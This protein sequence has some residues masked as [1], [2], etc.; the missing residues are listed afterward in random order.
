MLVKFVDTKCP[1]CGAYLNV[2]LDAGQANCQFCGAKLLIDDEVQ[3]FAYVNAEAAG[4]D[5]EKGRQRAQ[6]E[7][8]YTPP[9]PSPSFQEQPVKPKRKTWLWVLG[10]IFIFPV[11]L[12]ILLLRNQGM[13]KRLRVALIAAAWLVYLFMGFIGG[14]KEPTGDVSQG[15]HDDVQVEQAEQNTAEAVATAEQAKQNASNRS[16]TVA[17]EKSSAK[18]T[19]V[20]DDVVN[21]FIMSYGKVSSSPIASISNGNIR[22][23]YFGFSY[24]YYLEMLHANNADR[25]RVTISETN[26]NAD[27]GTAGMADVFHDVAVTID[28]D[29]TDEEIASYFGSLNNG[30]YS[31]IGSR[32]GA[33][34][35]K[36]S[37]DVELGSSYDRGHIVLSSK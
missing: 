1:N 23:K 11:P 18:D 13:D 29:L 27:E 36:Y 3:R 24:G 9:T 30:E 19:Q 34:E 14:T 5:F 35:I 28:P 4:Y 16:D 21:S 6:R 37:P 20:K 33:I 22:T 32:L 31:N 12:T 10:W 25:I 26:E 15:R 7:Q 2:D 8:V 17:K